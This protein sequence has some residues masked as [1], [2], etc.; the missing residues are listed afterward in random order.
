MLPPEI[1]RC[2][3]RID[4]ERSSRR[5]R[6]ENSA[7]D[8]RALRL[9]GKWKLHDE[10][11]PAQERRIE[12]VLHVGRQ[13][14]QPAIRLHPLEQIA[15]L[16]VGVTVVAVFHFAALAE[17]RVGFVE[18]QNRAAFLGGVE[19][20]PQILFR[21]AD[22]FAHHRAEIDPEKIEPQFVRQNFCRERFA[23]AARPGEKRAQA[24][25]ATRFFGK[26]PFVIDLRAMPHLLC[27]RLQGVHLRRGQDDVSPGRA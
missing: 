13:D 11:Q 2:A 26:T 10:T 5:L 23:R 7:P 15:D 20:A 22:V 14:G 12:R 8:F 19:H 25:P 1:E 6:W 17:K 18:K 4:V 16:D 3:R 21:L 27:D 9:I 24:E